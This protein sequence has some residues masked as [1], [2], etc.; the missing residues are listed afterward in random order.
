MESNYHLTILYY[1][2]CGLRWFKGFL[3]PWCKSMLKAATTC[4]SHAFH[5]RL[6]A[7][8]DDTELV[9]GLVLTQKVFG[10]PVD[11]HGVKL[12][13]CGQ[14]KSHIKPSANWVP[15]KIG[16]LRKSC[17]FIGMARY[18]L[19]WLNMCDL[20]SHFGMESYKRRPASCCGREPYSF[21]HAGDWR[22]KFLF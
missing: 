20:H 15:R 13:A 1:Q 9:D 6:G 18:G 12:G 5:V 4:G 16:S 21:G 22:L 7:T 2:S 3:C 8:T 14:K 17:H 19:V 10:A 11:E